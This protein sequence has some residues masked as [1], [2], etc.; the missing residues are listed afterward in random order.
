[1]RSASS[2]VRVTRS[3]MTTD[4]TANATRSGVSRGASAGAEGRE[5]E[6]RHAAA[7]RGERAARGDHD[8]DRARVA[9]GHQV[10]ADEQRR[11]ERERDHVDAQQC[12]NRHGP[13]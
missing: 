6:A 2:R 7:G 1:M 5:Q 9:V 12:A 11:G 8:R 13:E 4:A 10:R 3:K